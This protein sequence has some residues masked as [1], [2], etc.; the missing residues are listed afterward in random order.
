MSK[1]LSPK[2][3]EPKSCR[4]AFVKPEYDEDVIRIDGEEFGS[5]G[6]WFTIRWPNGVTEDVELRFREQYAG[7]T[8]QKVP[9]F[10]TNHNGYPLTIDLHQVEVEVE[11]D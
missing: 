5:E 10:I 4:R 8:T 6:E 11:V 7:G 9:C 2:V 3:R 1:F